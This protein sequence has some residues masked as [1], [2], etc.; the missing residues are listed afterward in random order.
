MP[1]TVQQT[2]A[3]KETWLSPAEAL[4]LN[5]WLNHHK[6]YRIALTYG[7]RTKHKPG[8]GLRFAQSDLEAALKLAG[9]DE[10]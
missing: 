3:S 8:F 10:E 5:S 7:V 6:L 9:P 2:V 1:A 4:K